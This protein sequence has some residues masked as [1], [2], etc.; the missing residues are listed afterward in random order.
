M[1]AFFHDAKFGEKVL[2]R[3]TR[4]WNKIIKESQKKKKGKE[5]QHLLDESKKA[6]KTSY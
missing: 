2:F 6:K 5:K 1:T 4:A 3:Q